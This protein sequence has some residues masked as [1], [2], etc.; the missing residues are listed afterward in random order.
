MLTARVFLSYHSCAPVW[1]TALSANY[2]GESRSVPEPLGGECGALGQRLKRALAMA[3][4]DVAPLACSSAIT[5][6]RSKG[7]YPGPPSPAAEDPLDPVTLCL[8]S[9]LATFLGTIML[10]GAREKR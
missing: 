3:R 8:E 7:S 4:S 10:K 5:G 2:S 6:A 9:C 1:R